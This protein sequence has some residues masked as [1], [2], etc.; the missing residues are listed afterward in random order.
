MYVYQ[1]LHWDCFGSWTANSQ[2]R[3]YHGPMRSMTMALVEVR[4]LLDYEAPRYV[5]E[6]KAPIC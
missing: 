5:S 2:A 4:A 6:F 1:C 3:V